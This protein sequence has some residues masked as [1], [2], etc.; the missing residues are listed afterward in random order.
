MSINVNYL[1]VSY[2]NLI[3]GDE[4]FA[5]EELRSEGVNIC[6]TKASVFVAEIKD[7][8]LEGGVE[9]LEEYLMENMPNV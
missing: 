2:K 3:F 6:E 4:F 7:L 9:Y 1:P 8:V 5:Q